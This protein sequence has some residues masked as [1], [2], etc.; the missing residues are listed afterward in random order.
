MA[1]YTLN[2]TESV[3]PYT[4]SNESIITENCDDSLTTYP[5]GLQRLVADPTRVYLVQNYTG[6]GWKTLHLTY[7]NYDVGDFINTGE[8][9]YLEYL[10]VKVEEGVLAIDIDVQSLVAGDLIPNLVIKST[11]SEGELSNR[12]ISLGY[13][14]E[15]TSNNIPTPITNLIT[16]NVITCSIPIGIALISGI[17][18]NTTNPCGSTGYDFAVS[19]PEGDSIN[20]VYRVIS[21]GGILFDGYIFRLDGPSGNIETE[22]RAVA[23]SNVENK[24][25]KIAY[26]PRI[27]EGQPTNIFYFRTYICSSPLQQT[28]AAVELELLENLGGAIVHTFNLTHTA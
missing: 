14:I 5:V 8:I 18:A 25:Y 3:P 17:T 6:I 22:D 13:S 1:K 24:D 9:F 21:N 10:G 19:V 28:P 4:E 2:I 23:M 26:N 7:I 15:D 11:V 27:I 12:L 20:F 16:E